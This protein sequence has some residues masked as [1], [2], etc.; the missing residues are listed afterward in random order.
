MPSVSLDDALHGLED[1]SRHRG[2][3]SDELVA[4][5]VD[6]ETIDDVVLILSE[7]LTNAFTHGRT[8]EATVRVTA[9]E[10]GVDVSV[11]HR[12]TAAAELPAAPAA[13]PASDLLSGRGLPIVDSLTIHR[14]TV[15]TDDRVVVT[16][17]VARSAQARRPR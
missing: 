7:L 1:L 8:D 2:F 17:R 3:V 13:M 11:G 9:D 4:L 14:D 15:V 10:I 6:A 12:R 16:C 5:G